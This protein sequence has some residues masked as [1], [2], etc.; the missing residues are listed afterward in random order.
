[1]S[2][3]SNS[4]RKSGTQYCQTSNKL[5]TTFDCTP[6]PSH[7]EQMTQIIRYV[8]INDC[9]NVVQGHIHSLCVSAKFVPCGRPHFKSCWYPCCWGF[10]THDYILLEKFKLSLIFFKFCIKMGKTD[11]NIEHLIKGKQ[12]HKVVCQKRSNHAIAQ[13]NQRSLKVLESLIHN[14]MTN[15]VTVCNAKELI[16]QINFSFLCLLDFWCQILSLMDQENKL[17]Q[18]KNFSIDIVAKK[19]KGLKAPIQ[20]LRVD[21]VDNIIKDAT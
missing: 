11:E 2:W 5:N 10:P 4:R 18:T 9:N 12:W 8:R 20:N 17:L 15:T 1:M 14:L 7:K 21:G 3:L 6:D 13:I 19:M 16:I